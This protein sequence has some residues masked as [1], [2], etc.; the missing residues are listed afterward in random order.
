MLNKALYFVLLRNTFQVV[1]VCIGVSMPP[2][3]P[4]PPLSYKVSPLNLKTVQAPL[5]KQSPSTLVFREPSLK[6]GFLSDPQ[7]YESFSSLT[8]SYL[9]KVTKFLV[10]LSQFEFLV[11]QRKIFLLINSFCR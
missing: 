3:K 9:L 4:P 11:M 2:S 1:I 6:V 5:F 7:K 8:L 10:E